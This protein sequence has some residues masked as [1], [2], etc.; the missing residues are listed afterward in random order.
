MKTK[1]L[2]AMLMAGTMLASSVPASALYSS[3]V[4]LLY[5]PYKVHYGKSYIGTRDTSAPSTLF[6]VG[7]QTFALLDTDEE[8]NYYVIA[9]QNYGKR[10]F[11]DREFFDRTIS[12]ADKNDDGTY[13]LFWNRAE[14]FDM[15]Y[16]RWNPEKEGTV[17]YWLNNDF[18]NSGELPNEITSNIVEHEFMVEGFEPWYDG[19][20]WDS[21]SYV[22]QLV[23]IPSG[24]YHESGY[25]D[26]LDAVL[27]RLK[28]DNYKTTSKSSLLS[29]SEWNA[30]ADK[31]GIPGAPDNE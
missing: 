30:Y 29:V 8:G 4:E 24:T 18:L 15:D 16:I 5:D 22:R 10:S 25:K 3:D 13:S 6:T 1:K 28:Q 14:N 31:V 26:A 9:E 23:G 20:L 11:W 7:G 21:D 27:L 17:A 19:M 12:R 2:I